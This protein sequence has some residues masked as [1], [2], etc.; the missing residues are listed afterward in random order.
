ML[1]TA[2]ASLITSGAIA[3]TTITG[4][5]RVSYKTNSMD[6]GVTNITTP[7]TQYGFGAEQQV[8]VQTKGKLNVG[9]LDYADGFSIENYGEQ[10]VTLFNENVYMDLTNASS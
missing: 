9:G 6:K 8:N 10:Q 2:L 3:Q 5:G 4:E 1:T 7:N